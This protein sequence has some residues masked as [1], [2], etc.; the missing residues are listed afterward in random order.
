[1]NAISKKDC[2]VYIRTHV[3][4]MHEQ[5]ASINIQENVEKSLIRIESR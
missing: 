2:F 4:M 1:M 5:N 3:N